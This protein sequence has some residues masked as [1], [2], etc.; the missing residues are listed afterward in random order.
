MERP[1]DAPRPE[2]ARADRI[3][4]RALERAYRPPREP[5]PGRALR[6]PGAILYDVEPV[7]S[8]LR[9]AIQSEL[10]ANEPAPPTSNDPRTAAILESPL[11]SED[12][13]DRDAR[14]VLLHSTRRSKLLM[15]AAMDHVVDGP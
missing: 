4:G 14:V 13:S 8:P 2:R 9:V 15:A 7:N 3:R 10:I 6:A 5:R 11:E 12:F 1:R